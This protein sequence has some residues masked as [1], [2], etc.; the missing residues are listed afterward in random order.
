MDGIKK[1]L[2]A[3]AA[4]EL[5]VFGAVLIFVIGAIIKQAL[6]VGYWQNQNLKAMRLALKASYDSQ[7]AGDIAARRMATVLFVEDRLT[8][9]SAKYGAIDRTPHMVQ[10]SGSHNSNLFMP[11]DWP[12][13]EDLSVMDVIVNGKRFVFT[14]GGW[15]T[16]TFPT[17]TGP[18]PV[19]GPGP[20]TTVEG[21]STDQCGG[22]SKTISVEWDPNCATVTRTS[23]C[24][25]Q[26]C[27][28]DEFGAT[29][30]TNNCASF[31]PDFG[32]NCDTCSSIP[33]STIGPV[34]CPVSPVPCS[35]YVTPV[36]GLDTDGNS[37]WI[38]D[39][40]G[41]SPQSVTNTASRGCANLYRIIDN[42]PLITEWDS[43]PSASSRFDLDR[44]LTNLNR[45]GIATP[46]VL[47]SDQQYFA[48]QWYL[49]R[50][51]KASSSDDVGSVAIETS[52]VGVS[53]RSISVSSGA[54]IDVSDGKNMDFDVDADLE[55]E[56]IASKTSVFTD[57]DSVVNRIDVTDP[58]EGDVDFSISKE[59]GIKPM[60]GFTKETRM[61]TFVQDKALSGNS[62]TYFRVEE[63]KLFSA[64]GNQFIRTARKKDQID[65]I[66]RVFQ[67]SNDTG[68][69]CNGGSPTNWASSPYAGSFQG[70]TNPVEVCN[71]CF[72]SAN[73]NRTCM[74]TVNLLI[75]IRSSIQDLR[76][77]KWVTD[78]SGDPYVNF[79]SP[80]GY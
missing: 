45:G 5:A 11:V 80:A 15:R 21:T 35:P 58:N 77:R 27:Y 39:I 76:G 19:P 38:Y 4:I 36:Y 3:Q 69:Y 56:Y 30:C 34:V 50:G 40:Y 2:K 47:P 62:G 42:H 6:A 78:T 13:C 57:A 16:V 79:M 20:V 10:G 60:A 70:L 53:G 26:S 31:C 51:I 52:E 37:I 1:Q 59:N 75:F 65:L 8:A 25:P 73:I 17:G 66:E 24:A 43:S 49:T 71:N 12:S 32:N 9:D 72:T 55:L 74:D 44:G 7:M 54:L 64:T 22:P 48:W 29:I 18:I 61:Y 14:M 23:P 67:L 46:A 33:T 41:C 63:G 28:V 68:R